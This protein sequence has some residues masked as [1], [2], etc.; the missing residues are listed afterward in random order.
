[1][2]FFKVT[3]KEPTIGDC[4]YCI[5]DTKQ[6]CL[7]KTLV[8]WVQYPNGNYDWDLKNVQHFGNF[9]EDAEV[10]EWLDESYNEVGE[11]L[12]NE[13]P[14]EVYPRAESWLQ[15]R[16]NFVCEIDTLRKII[17]ESSFKGKYERTQ[18]P[19]ERLRNK[20]SP[21]INLVE[22]LGSTNNT[23]KVTFGNSTNNEELNELFLGNLK[24][25][26]DFKKD[27]KNHLSDCETFYNV[28]ENY[29]HGLKTDKVVFFTVDEIGDFISENGVKINTSMFLEYKSHRS[30]TFNFLII[31]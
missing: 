5:V 18:T 11:L 15:E 21:F 22:I 20:L 29:T 24:T 6:D 25:C 4:Y 17:N 1:M 27:V 12:P 7:V 31:K 9:G 23:F 28:R 13:H 26:L 3:E 19:I 8:D 10:I 2:K 14:D 30:S 16:R